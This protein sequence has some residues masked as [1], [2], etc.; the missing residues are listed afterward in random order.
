MVQ[1]NTAA[2]IG[3]LFPALIPNLDT[4]KSNKIKYTEQTKNEEEK[5]I[6]HSHTHQKIC[7]QLTS[8]SNLHDQAIV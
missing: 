4:M 7:R 5:S 8:H 3:R 6:T 2:H 1:L